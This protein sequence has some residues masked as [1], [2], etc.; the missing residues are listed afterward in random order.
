MNNN[1]I[2]IMGGD[3]SFKEVAN[4]YLYHLNLIW[5]MIREYS[6]E[7]EQ[8]FRAFQQHRAFARKYALSRCQY[9]DGG[10]TSKALHSWRFFV[11]SSSFCARG[12]GLVFHPWTLIVESWN[13][14][15]F[16]KCKCNDYGRGG[17]TMKMKDTSGS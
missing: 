12:C 5:F 8:M 6:P 10:T 3:L 11:S 4:L 16:S 14:S 2:N 7:G 15:L 1:T 13:R 9:D 17:W